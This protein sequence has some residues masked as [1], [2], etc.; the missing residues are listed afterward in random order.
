MLKKIYDKM[1]CAD[2]YSPSH[3]EDVLTLKTKIIQLSNLSHR[4]VEELYGEFSEDLYCASWLCLDEDGI[5]QFRAWL[6]I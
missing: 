4:Q 5:E 6:D 3:Y 2:C 1:R